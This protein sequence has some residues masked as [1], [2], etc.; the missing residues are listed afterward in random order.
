MTQLTNIISTIYLKCSV[1]VSWDF[2]NP[3]LAIDLGG[4]S[5]TFF[6][7]CFF[8]LFCLSGSLPPQ[9]YKLI[10]WI[11]HTSILGINNIL[12][13]L[14]NHFLQLF[15]NCG[16]CYVHWNT[17]NLRKYV[18]IS[19]LKFKTKTLSSRKK[20]NR[21]ERPQTFFFLLRVSHPTVKSI[22]NAT[23]INLFLL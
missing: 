13:Y 17:A 21:N 8:A 14:R 12:F 10:P 5:G 11:Y 15:G 16:Y 7:F 23:W 3:M 18:S 1:K 22:S 2:K 9:I 19:K 20:D 4:I 6:L